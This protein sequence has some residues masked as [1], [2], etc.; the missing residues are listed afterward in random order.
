MSAINDGGP[1]FP[2]YEIFTD[3]ERSFAGHPHGG[4][5][6]RDWLAGHALAGYLAAFG[7]ENVSLPGWASAAKSA[8]GYADAMLAER[9]RKKEGGAA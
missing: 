4:M 3:G 6:L 1:A 7:V 9:D 5:K 2:G 8:Y